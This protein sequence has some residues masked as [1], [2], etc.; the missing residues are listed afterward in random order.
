VINE[1][2]PTRQIFVNISQSDCNFY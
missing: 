1:M 2:I